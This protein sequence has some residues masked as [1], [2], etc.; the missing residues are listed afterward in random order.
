MMWTMRFN[1][2]L[3]WAVLLVVSSGCEEPDPESGILV[4]VQQES[5]DF[6][7]DEVEIRGY[8]DGRLFDAL[9]DRRLAPSSG[10]LDQSFNLFVWVPTA[11]IGQT[12]WLDI[13]GYRNDVATSHGQTS[14]VPVDGRIEEVTILLKQG[15]PPCGNG[16]IDA[17]E[18]C[19]ATDLAGQ[20]CAN[21]AGLGDGQLACVDCQLDTLDCHECG[22]GAI[23]GPAE[24]CDG[25]E[26]GGATCQARG[27][28]RGELRCG[29]D[30][31]LDLTRCE[32][33]CGNGIIEDAEQCDAT[34]LGGLGCP[35]FGFQRGYLLCD[36][37][38][39]LDLMHCE[40]TCGDGVADPGESCDGTDFGTQSCV[41]AAGRPSGVLGCTSSCHLDVSA[42]HDCGDGVIEGP[43][44]CDTNNLGGQDCTDH[45]LTN[46]ILSCD[47]SCLY[48]TGGCL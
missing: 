37:S 7:V 11:W 24:D 41:T 16:T 42:C 43:E 35:D 25:S 21:V 13:I 38:C 12:V 23:E 20:T 46:G 9:T 2:V 31:R 17:G 45:G 4:N 27:F 30:C 33:G 8:P 19:E 36:E 40:G 18:Q 6:E 5:G 1:L 14:V 47:A 32:N 48:D 15:P 28:L 3:L 39:Q 22:N 29:A 10:P 34:N 44:Q 26:L